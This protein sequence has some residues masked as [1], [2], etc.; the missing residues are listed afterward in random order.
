M[1]KAALD[2]QTKINFVLPHVPIDKRIIPNDMLRSSLFNIS[3]HNRQRENL[4]DKKLC[5]FKSTEM[6]YT[7]EELRQDDEDVWLQL[8]YLASKNQTEEI[9]F[10][11][12]TFLSQLGWP[13]RTQYKDSLIRALDRMSASTLK[14]YNRDF[15]QGIVFSLIRKY[16]WFD[17]DRTKLKNLVVWLEPEIVRL[18]AVLGRMYSK[19]NW[20]QRKKLKLLA[21]WLHAFYSTHADPKPI[22]IS[23]LME[24]SGSKT[25]EFK[26]FKAMLINALIELVKIGFLEQDIFIDKKFYVHVNRKKL[27]YKWVS[28]E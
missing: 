12:Y 14:I 10:K 28:Y 9:H 2:A 7:G 15:K 22:H 27:A 18:F 20:E 24:L 25:K 3:N 6:F 4:K 11:P 5:T 21:K 23:K 1:S 13:K 17:S 19:I 26:H 16:E 8:I